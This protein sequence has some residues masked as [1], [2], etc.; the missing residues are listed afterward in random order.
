MGTISVITWRYS[1]G[2]GMGVV[3][4][5]QDEASARFDLSML[6]DQ[7]DGSRIF[8]VHDVPYMPNCPV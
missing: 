3:R 6:K 4:A 5:Y 7:C 2:S 8:E 1:D